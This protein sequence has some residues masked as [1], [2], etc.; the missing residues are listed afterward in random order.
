MKNLCV[1]LS[2]CVLSVGITACGEPSPTLTAPD[3]ARF[4]GGYTFGGGNK[5]DSTTVA[6]SSGET[7]TKSDSTTT[8]RGGHT[9]GGGN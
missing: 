4:D 3:A 9:F 8:E 7:T 5:S 1:L 6:T 2:A